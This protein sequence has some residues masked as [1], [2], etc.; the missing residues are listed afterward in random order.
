MPPQ[1][2]PSSATALSSASFARAQSAK[3]MPPAW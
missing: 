3:T 1:P 2:P